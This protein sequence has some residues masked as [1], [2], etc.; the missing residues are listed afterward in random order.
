VLLNIPIDHVEVNTS[1]TLDYATVVGLPFD[2]PPRMENI[3]YTAQ[4][5]SS[6]PKEE[7]ETLHAAVDTNCPVLNTLR[8]PVEVRQVT[9]K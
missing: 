8:F 1:G 9:N 3:T 7:I 5:E 6:A 2:E 4:V